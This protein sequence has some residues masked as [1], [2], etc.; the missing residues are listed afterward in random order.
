MRIIFQFI[1][2]KY[3]SV[4]F[5]NIRLKGI[6]VTKYKKYESIGNFSTYNSEEW[7]EKVIWGFSVQTT[8]DF[9]IIITD[10]G[11]REATQKLD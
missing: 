7:L 4:E 6:F 11:S 5:L 3:R 1:D 8:K 10:D 2:N 9:E